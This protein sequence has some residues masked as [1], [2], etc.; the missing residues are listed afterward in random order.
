MR[1]GNDR[2]PSITRRAQKMGAVDQTQFNL[3]ASVKKADVVMLCVPVDEIKFTLETIAPDLKE[4]CVVI[5]TSPVKVGVAEWA[6]QLLPKDRY[7]V[8]MT[9]TLNPAYLEETAVGINAAHA[10]LF[11]NSLMVIT[12]LPGTDADA[13][14][15]ATDLA[16]LLGGT[17][18][19]ADAYESDGLMA[20]VH[21]LPHLMAA[22]L[23]DSTTNQPGW[24]E[25][26]KVAGQAYARV[27][28]PLLD[29]L[30]AQFYGQTALLN[31]TNTLRVLDNVIASLRAM[32]QSLADDNEEELAQ[33]IRGA[34]D[35]RG[36][37]QIQREKSD[38]NLASSNQP[39]PTSGEILG[40][41]FGLGKRKTTDKK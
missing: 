6:K 40:R 34:V 32:R 2:E 4:G 36:S 26:R 35:A 19:F 12:S 16:M 11:K 37:W 18:Y 8:T 5:D 28:Y 29:P 25:A 24:N 14:K 20:A 15:L 30:E 38:W 7:F 31:K 22:A 3:P 33:R 41:L 21:L 27:S 10:D 17:P 13:L 39:L 9:P 23:V 1:M